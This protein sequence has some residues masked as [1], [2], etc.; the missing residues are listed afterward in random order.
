MTES[1]HSGHI[2]CEPDTDKSPVGSVSSLL[3]TL[4]VYRPLASAGQTPRPRFRPTRLTIAATTQGAPSRIHT[5]FA[6][7]VRRLWVAEPNQPGRHRLNLHRYITPIDESLIRNGRPTPHSKSDSRVVF[8]C[9]KLKT[10]GDA[11]EWGWR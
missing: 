3:P 11:I 4:L 8:Q 5:S 7:E 1:R 6:K 10:P 2:T 9:L